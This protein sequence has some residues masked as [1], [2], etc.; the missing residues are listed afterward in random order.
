MD[1][2]NPDESA[3]RVVTVTLSP[4]EVARFRADREWVAARIAEAEANNE[5]RPQRWWDEYRGCITELDAL[6]AANEVAQ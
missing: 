3:S 2:A 1:T 4:D 5:K 6:I